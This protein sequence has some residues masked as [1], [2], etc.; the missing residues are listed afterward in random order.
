MRRNVLI[1]SP[2][3]GFG[4]LIRQVVEENGNFEAYLAVDGKQANT[5]LDDANAELLI[6]DGELGIETIERLIELQLESNPKSKSLL[7]PTEDA[8]LNRELRQL[9][10]DRTLSNPFYLPD[11]I[12]SLQS[13]FGPSEPV[14]KIG[15]ERGF[16]PP[17]PMNTPKKALKAPDW[18]SDA[19]LA[20]QYLM[21]LSLE[22]SAQAALITHRDQIWAYSGELSQASVAEIAREI[23][24]QLDYEAQIDL[25]RFIQP[26]ADRN[27]YMLYATA[28]GGDYVLSLIF[29]TAIPFS[30]MREQADFLAQSLAKQPAL[31]LAV[32]QE[33]SVNIRAESTAS[34][35]FLNPEEQS[36]AEAFSFEPVET[37]AQQSNV[38]IP[39]VGTASLRMHDD[40]IFSFVLVPRMPNHQLDI[41]LRNQLSIWLPQMCVA[42]GWR[43]ERY[44]IRQDYVTWTVHIG[45]HSSPQS[46]ADK[47]GIQLS[48]R[49]FE[50]LPRLAR[51]N[52]SGEFWASG[53]L[54]VSGD[55]PNQTTI[56]EYIR[57]TRASQGLTA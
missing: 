37:P 30:K 3:P 31:E 23:N 43:L 42:F 33:E 54:I 22:S 8:E 25:A 1:L 51:E 46:V 27:G 28:L 57:E 16:N 21:R 17:R 19:D 35:S 39:N 47:M 9:D 24:A 52:P 41:G 2:N 20:A 7:I 4:E 38:P 18:L 5:A 44:E 34:D 45:K 11:L 48:Q 55:I 13:F 32:K 53:A 36:E 40:L 29:D 26:T 12:E 15:V 49:I 10:F 50:E 14:R 56:D 6:L